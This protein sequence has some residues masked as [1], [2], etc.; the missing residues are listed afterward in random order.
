[1]KNKL[2]DAIYGLAVGDALGVPFE[3][4]KRGTFECTGM[5]GNGTHNQ[6]AGTW[7]D[8]T[9]MTLATCWSI[10]RKDGIVLQDIRWQFEEWL[11]RSHFTAHGEV[12]DVGGTTSQAIYQGHGMNDV[13]SNGNGSL[14][15][16]IPLAFV[17]G[18]TEKDIEDVSSITHG[19]LISREACKLYV[20]IARF[21]AKG[22]DLVEILT[23]SDLL[24][25]AE[26][27]F[28]RLKYIHTLPEKE[29][30]STGYVVDT[31]EAALWCVA[32]T[33]NYKDC[34]LKA[35]NLGSDTDTVAAVAGGLAGIIYGYDAIP[36]E[37]IQELANKKLI[38][39]CL[40]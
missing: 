4:M 36:K 35:V 27:P 24:Q 18:I 21:L 17:K 33:D 13:N 26:K 5:V 8:D 11:T 25:K 40:F 12:F 7:S 22:H 34:V 2:R 23:L 38:E 20:F 31:L 16:I 32:T 10:K 15:R 19:H 39:S 1:M 9:S 30:K 6:P 37:W 3:F 28:D 29:I 14:M